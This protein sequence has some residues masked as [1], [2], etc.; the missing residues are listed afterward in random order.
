MLTGC[1]NEK[2]LEI[3]LLIPP[4]LTPSSFILMGTQSTEQEET[5]AA[6]HSSWRRCWASSHPDPR[7][8][9]S[10][11]ARPWP[12]VHGARVFTSPP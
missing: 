1:K 2:E 7:P 11:R 5:G 10:R 4:H 9:L 3:S 8:G 6:S 12:M